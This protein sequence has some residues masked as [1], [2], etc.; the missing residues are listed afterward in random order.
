MNKKHLVIAGLVASAALVAGCKED[1]KK[2][3]DS[4][5]IATL[6]QKV[7]YIIGQNMAKSLQQNGVVLESDA[8][9]LAVSDV[10]NATPTRIPEEEMQKIMQEMQQKVMAKKEEEQKKLSET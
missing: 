9:L 3:D 2:Q 1:A 7:S 4:T 8:F 6:E 5:K 10:K